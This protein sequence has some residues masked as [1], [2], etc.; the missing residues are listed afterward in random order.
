MTEKS[1]KA[2]STRG[3]IV[4]T[5]VVVLL[6]T[7]LALWLVEPPRMRAE[8]YAWFPDGTT[9]RVSPDAGTYYQSCVHPAGTS[10]VFGGAETGPPRIWRADLGTGQ[11]AP[12]T[13]PDSAAFLATYSWDGASIVFSSDRAF[14]KP[15]IAVQDTPDPRLYRPA[16]TGEHLRFFNL[17]VAPDAGGDARQVTRGRFRDLRATFA[18]DG[19]RLAFV[20]TR[21]R[22][23]SPLFTVDVAGE[24]TP[25]AIPFDCDAWNA[26]RPWYTADGSE[27]YF[28]GER[29]STEP[30]G[31]ASRKRIAH[32]PVAGGA[33]ET[34]AWDDR[35]KSQGPFLDPSGASLLFHTDRTGRSELWELPFDGGEARMLVPPGLDLP[36]DRELMHPTRARNGVI[37]FDASYADGSALHRALWALRARLASWMRRLRGA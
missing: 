3:R 12:I 33:V 28:F 2:R 37:T 21:E 23:V 11:V 26:Y 34:V 14:D 17:F 19:A 10:V 5:G 4:R 35:G 22:R 29:E 6:S 27:L 20:S 36:D 31:A 15:S 7:A 18:P 8:V 25:R 16:T 1:H 24:E 13:P 9:R 30:T 32:L